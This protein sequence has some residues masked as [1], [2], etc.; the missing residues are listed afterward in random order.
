VKRIGGKL[1][2]RIRPVCRQCPKQPYF[3]AAQARQLRATL[4][5]GNPREFGRVPGLN[6][7]SRFA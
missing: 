6:L 4:V 5:T 3:I 2:I 1:P 7:A